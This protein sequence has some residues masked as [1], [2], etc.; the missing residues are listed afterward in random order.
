MINAINLLQCDY[1]D[2][3]KRYCCEKSAFMQGRIL[4][5]SKA[6]VNVIFVKFKCYVKEKYNKRIYGY[7]PYCLSQDDIN[8]WNV[9]G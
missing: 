2:C 8:T 1:C 9:Y 4:F 6:Y 7:F 5:D 3:E